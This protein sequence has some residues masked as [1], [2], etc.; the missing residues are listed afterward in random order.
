[1]C[2]ETSNRLRQTV[3]LVSPLKENAQKVP[4]RRW[5]LLHLEQE[6]PMDLLQQ[7]A[8]EFDRLIPYQ[9]HIIIGRKGK[10]LEFTISF[11][12]ADFHHLAGLHKLRD[13]VRLQTGKRFDIMK[14]IL[15]GRLTYSDI[16]QSSFFMRWNPVS[17]RFRSWNFFWTATKLFSD[18]MPKQI[19]FLLSRL[20]ISCKMIMKGHP[21]IYFSRSVLAV[22]HRYAAHSSQKR[23]KIMQKDSH[24]IHYLKRKRRT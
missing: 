16:K 23:E 4:T 3:P 2:S 19:F 20:T 5:G 7:C 12:R 10:T 11:D 1:M 14:E 18:T 17:C 21:F 24:G 9:Y 15:D 8:Q 6:I 22:T 13:N